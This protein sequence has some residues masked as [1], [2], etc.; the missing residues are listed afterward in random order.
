MDQTELVGANSPRLN[1][2][3]VFLFCCPHW[4]FSNIQLQIN[5]LFFIQTLRLHL[6]LLEDLCS[7]K[8]WFIYLSISFILGTAF[9]SVSSSLSGSKKLLIFFSLF[10][11][12][13][14]GLSDA[15]KLLYMWNQKTIILFSIFKILSFMN[16]GEFV[17]DIGSLVSLIFL[18]SPCL[19]V[20]F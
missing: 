17:I 11:I 2:L 10:C 8:P 1:T 14:L 13:L 4:A 7:G 19:I 12:L 5:F 15:I 3:G 6:L 20:F 18:W 16:F 9:Y